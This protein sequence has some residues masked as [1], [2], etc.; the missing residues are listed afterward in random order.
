MIGIGKLRKLKG[1][2]QQV[3]QNHTCRSKLRSFSAGR[4]ETC[5][6][7]FQEPA[8]NP[9]SKDAQGKY[10][11]WT[12]APHKE[13]HTQQLLDAH[14]AAHN[15]DEIAVRNAGFFKFQ[16]S[17]EVPFSKFFLFFPC[18]IKVWSLIYLNLVFMLPSEAK[19]LCTTCNEA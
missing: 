12:C 9:V 15:S 3:L 17:T 18:L 19:A 2:R 16:Y 7:L 5:A 8:G 10:N 11:C 14:L 4:L 6:P 1:F 13:S